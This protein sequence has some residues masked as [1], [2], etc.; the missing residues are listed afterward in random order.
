MLLNQTILFSSYYYTLE[1]VILY[2]I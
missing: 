1:S 2:R